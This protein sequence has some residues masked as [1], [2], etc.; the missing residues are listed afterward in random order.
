MVLSFQSDSAKIDGV[1][2]KVVL[3][4]GLEFG[5]ITKS[6]YNISRVCAKVHSQLAKV[7]MV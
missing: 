4:E 3:K 5:T 7:S 1:K 6:L 2:V